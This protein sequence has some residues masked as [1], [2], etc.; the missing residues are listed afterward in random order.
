MRCSCGKSNGRGCTCSKLPKQKTKIMISLMAALLFFVVA[1]PDTFK[2]VRNVVGPWVASPTG[3]PTMQGLVLHSVVYLL[4]TWIIMNVNKIEKAE[5]SN[6]P[7]VVSEQELDMLSNE[8]DDSNTDAVGELDT[9]KNSAEKNDMVVSE[10]ELNQVRQ[11]VDES[12]LKGPLLSGSKPMKEESTMKPMDILPMEEES[13]I[14]GLDVLEIHDDA[15]APLAPAHPAPILDTG[16]LPPGNYSKC[17][18]DN[19]NELIIMN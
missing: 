6:E 13:T 5:G 2:M 7:V 9:L 4:L 3:C 17:S 16:L 10:E 18:C 14:Q 15:G 1:N 8:V 19:G 11:T 12:R